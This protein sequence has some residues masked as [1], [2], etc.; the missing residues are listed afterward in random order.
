MHIFISVISL[1]SAL[2]LS[3]APELMQQYI[4][5]LGGVV[6]TP[7]RIVQHFD[8]DSARSGYD[9]SGALA[10][11]ARNPIRWREMLERKTYGTIAE[12]ADAERI[13]GAYVGRVLRLT[14][15][16]PQLVENL[17]SGRHA[18]SLTVADLLLPF[19]VEWWAQY[20]HFDIQPP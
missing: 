16:A 15:L 8:E 10:L 6:D 18:E 5:R 9:R 17:L 19:P 12:I 2:L 1:A 13:N 20:R 14:L 7:T 3:Q 4:Q 11:M